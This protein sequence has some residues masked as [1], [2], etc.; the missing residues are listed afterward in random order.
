MFHFPY[1]T[2]TIYYL[3]PEV[4]GGAYFD[5]RDVSYC[6]EVLFRMYLPLALEVHNRLFIDSLGFIWW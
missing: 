4:A 1:T 2:N 5:R 3:P 6:H